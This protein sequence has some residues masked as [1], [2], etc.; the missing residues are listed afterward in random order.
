MK[1]HIDKFWT[2]DNPMECFEANLAT[3]QDAVAAG[4]T[5][6]TLPDT[7]MQAAAISLALVSIDGSPVGQIWTYAEWSGF[8]SLGLSREQGLSA[9]AAG[10]E[11]IGR[12]DDARAFQA[13][14]AEAGGTAT[15]AS[16]FP[17]GYTVLNARDEI[18]D[19]MGE[20]LLN[21]I[22]FVALAKDDLKEHW[23]GLARAD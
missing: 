10:L 21:E 15:D 22:E 6:E 9:L 3:L 12:T 13:A 23:A 4:V 5:A 7:C 19:A 20:L 18:A 11:R 8:S 14:T 16:G 17:D 2:V 1:L